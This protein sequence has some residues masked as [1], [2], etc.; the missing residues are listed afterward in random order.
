MSPTAP[1]SSSP[2]KLEPGQFKRGKNVTSS[3]PR[4]P[5]IVAALKA[6]SACRKVTSVVEVAPNT[7]QGN[8]M[9]PNAG[10]V[11]GFWELQ[12]GQIEARRSSSA[13]SKPECSCSCMGGSPGPHHAGPCDLFV[14]VRA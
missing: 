13:R 8:C 3:D 7:Y 5:A 6:V 12:V 9:N 11:P 14:D 10:G 2:R 4:K 1:V